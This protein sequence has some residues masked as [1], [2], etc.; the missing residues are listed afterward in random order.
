MPTIL[1]NEE[2]MCML[3]KVVDNSANGSVDTSASASSAATVGNVS[4]VPDKAKALQNII[5]Y[6]S[7]PEFPLPNLHI[8]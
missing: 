4:S 5:D 7:G 1:Q 8:V 2:E 6:I 3:K